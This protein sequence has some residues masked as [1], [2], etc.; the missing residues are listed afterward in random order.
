MSGGNI[1]G[2]TL[3]RILQSSSVGLPARGPLEAARTGG[4]A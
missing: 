3:Q 4:E 1:D 2:A